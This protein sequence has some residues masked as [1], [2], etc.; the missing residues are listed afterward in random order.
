[1]EMKLGF[2]QVYNEAPWVG[3]AIDQ[4]MM[5]CDKL[6][7]CEGSQF[8]TYP[9]I[10]ERS[11]DGT[12]DIIADKKR[13]HSGR[14]KVINTVRIHDNYR[15]NQC[16]NFNVA[17]NHCNIEDYF[18]TLDADFYFMNDCIS[19][20]NDLMAQ[21]A[22]DV[23]WFK[24]WLFT[25]S[26]Y[27]RMSIKADDL[28]CPTIYRKTSNFRFIPTH[29][30]RNIGERVI[31]TDKHIMF[32]YTW[33]KPRSRVEIRQRTSG[34]YRE[35]EKWFNKSW[36]NIELIDGKS[37][38]CWAN[39]DLTLKRYDGEHPEILD[40]HPWRHIEDVRKIK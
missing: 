6:L 8:V 21:E 27:W 7:I 24:E 5:I 26:F 29:R 14:I 9:D 2:L 36:D 20:I 37:Y 12:L 31:K 34:R 4:A 23:L 1:M 33:V 22:F 10:P 19:W 15:R 11:N 25:Y 32:H 38:P 17:L 35:M 39:M 3:F 40:N 18:I 30:A 28:F 16:A 13:Q